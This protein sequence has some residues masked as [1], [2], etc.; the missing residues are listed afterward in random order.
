MKQYFAKY[1]P[2]DEE[3][4][5]GD[6]VLENLLTGEKEL[7]Q[8]DSENDIDLSVQ[9]KVK[10]FICSKDIKKGDKFFFRENNPIYNSPNEQI[11]RRLEE[12]MVEENPLLPDFMYKVV[13]P[14]SE[15]ATFV[16]EGDEFDKG[17]VKV[18]VSPASYASKILTETFGEIWM[19]KEDVIIGEKKVAY[20]CI[21]DKS[22]NFK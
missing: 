2:V 4:K 3:I 12:K 14:L 8:I 5:I 1:L 16:K 18:F 11:Y 22:G 9:I 19:H 7:F 10:L 6:I 21:K 15:E 20:V 13:G 17:D